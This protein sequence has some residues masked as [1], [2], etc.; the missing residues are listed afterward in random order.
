MRS[1]VSSNMEYRTNRNSF[2]RALTK[3]IQLIHFTDMKNID[4]KKLGSEISYEY[5]NL[6]DSYFEYTNAPVTLMNRKCLLLPSGRFRT[7][8]D[9]LLASRMSRR[10]LTWIRI[11]RIGNASFVSRWNRIGDTLVTAKYEA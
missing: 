8:N 7:G 1:A 4:R 2:H 10:R 9:M 11:V 3:C 5:D 6:F